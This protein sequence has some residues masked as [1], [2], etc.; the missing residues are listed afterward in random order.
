[1]I[2]VQVPQDRETP[3]RLVRGSDFSFRYAYARARESREADDRGQDSLVIRSAPGS[4]AFCLCA[5][6]SQSFYGDLAARFLGEALVEWLWDDEFAG[7]PIDDVRAVLTERLEGATDAGTD[8][9]RQQQFPAGLPSLV[10]QVLEEKRC[11]GSETVFACG[12]LD[13]GPGREAPGRILLAWMGDARLRLWVQAREISRDLGGVFETRQRWSSRRAL[14]N[15]PL[16]V[17]IG[18]LAGPAGVGVTRLLAY[19][20]GLSRL[21]PVGHVL[22]PQELEEALAEADG[23]PTSD[24]VTFLE[25]WAG[26]GVSDD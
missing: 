19:S 2:V 14:V 15:G 23:S 6:V 24:D 9:V 8:L 3:P 22:T 7:L 18:P 16:N 4:L 13:V 12:R 25:V 5:G 1:M 11:L 10:Q 17:Y 21:D 20:D 26:E